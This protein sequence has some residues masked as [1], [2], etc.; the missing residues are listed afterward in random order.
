MW[1]ICQKK[2]KIGS[3]SKH[4]LNTSLLLRRRFAFPESLKSLFEKE[5]NGKWIH[6]YLN[7]EKSAH[8][9]NSTNGALSH[10]LH[11][12]GIISAVLPLNQLNLWASKSRST[13]VMGATVKSTK[14][15]HRCFA[16]LRIIA[17]STWKN[18]KQVCSDR[19]LTQRRLSYTHCKLNVICA[20]NE[21]HRN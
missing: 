10:V 3:F 4:L 15:K 20:F 18:A 19:W 12:F 13:S 11:N 7:C 9:A 21:W 1:R 16:S 6:V 14:L 2:R 5:A 8:S 17:L